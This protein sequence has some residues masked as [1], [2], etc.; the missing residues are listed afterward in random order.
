[1]KA[2][3]GRGTK[4]W[5][6][7]AEPAAISGD[8]PPLGRGHAALLL[9]VLQDPADVCSGPGRAAWFAAC[10]SLDASGNG[11]T[12]TAGWRTLVRVWDGREVRQYVDGLCTNTTAM[13]AT[14]SWTIH[15]ALDNQG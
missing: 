11:P 7:S 9:D 5:P 14:G 1:M 10:T 4:I 6:I 3:C 13:T 12:I 2:T 15:V 8:Q